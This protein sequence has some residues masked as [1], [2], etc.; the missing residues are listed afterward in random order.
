[1]EKHKPVITLF[2]CVNAFT[3]NAAGTFT[4]NNGYELKSVNMAC[5]SMVKDVYLLRA[6]ESGSDA[7]VVLVCPEDQCRHIEGSIRAGKRVERTKKILDEIGIDSE[8]LAIYNISSNDQ[9]AVGKIL[10]N[11]AKKLS[12]RSPI[13]AAA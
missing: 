10:Q 7:V 3:E 5:S 8:R 9:L 4:N 11:T 13:R 2:H 1:M 12:G 6:F